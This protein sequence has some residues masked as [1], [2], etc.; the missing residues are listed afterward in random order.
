MDT[1]NYTY[2]TQ[3]ENENKMLT[4]EK[5]DKSDAL[6]EKLKGL[7][8]NNTG[9]YESDSSNA[10]DEKG[11]PASYLKIATH[12]SDGKKI[13][14]TDTSKGYLQPKLLSNRNLPIITTRQICLSMVG[15]R[16]F[17]HICMWK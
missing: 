12:T 15:D 10:N 13:K 8:I 5:R 17:E 1:F 16:I 6:A 3:R 7:T 2:N 9:Y 11:D 4:S 14:V